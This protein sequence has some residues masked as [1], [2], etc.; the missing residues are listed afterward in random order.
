MLKSMLFFRSQPCDCFVFDTE[1]MNIRPLGSFL[2]LFCDGGSSPVALWHLSTLRD[3]TQECWQCP[4]ICAWIGFVA[5]FRHLGH[6]GCFGPGL[7]HGF[8]VKVK[9]PIDSMTVT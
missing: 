1:L 7:K 9:K 4:E 8:G 2:R 3:L 6:L 5:R